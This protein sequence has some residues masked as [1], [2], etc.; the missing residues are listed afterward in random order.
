MACGIV[1]IGVICMTEQEIK[2]IIEE[3]DRLQVERDYYRKKLDEEKS[4]QEWC[5]KHRFKGY[6]AGYL[7]RCVG[8]MFMIEHNL[9]E[10]IEKIR[11][12]IRKLAHNPAI[13]PEF[14]KALDMAE[15]YLRLYMDYRKRYYELLNSD[16]HL[17]NVE[18]RKMVAKKKADDMKNGKE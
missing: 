13:A 1:Q 18:L 3:R 2:K 9:A 8:G 17:R 15:I 6:A 11:T 4:Y 7:T 12:S 16:K 5:Q 10:N 14:Q